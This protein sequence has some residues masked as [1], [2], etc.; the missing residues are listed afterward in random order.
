MRGWLTRRVRLVSLM[1]RHPVLATALRVVCLP[2][3]AW[4]MWRDGEFVD[5]DEGET[6]EERDGF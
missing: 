5:D 2:A 4:R 1:H 3:T 6:E